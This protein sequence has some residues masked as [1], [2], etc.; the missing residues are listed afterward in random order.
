MGVGKAFNAQEE[1][2]GCDR[3]AKP[4]YPVGN[5]NSIKH[6]V[7]MVDEHQGNPN[8]FNVEIGDA[9]FVF[10]A[11]FDKIT[12]KIL[13]YAKCNIGFAFFKKIKNE[14]KK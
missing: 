7:N 14:F 13:Q 6:F 4:I 10:S 3:T 8:D 11:D 12:P 5:P 2:N 9:P 1:E